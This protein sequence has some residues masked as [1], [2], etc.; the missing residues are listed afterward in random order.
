MQVLKVYDSSR[1]C[2]RVSV[3]LPRVEYFLQRVNNN[4]AKITKVNKI[5][6][7]QQEVKAVKARELVSEGE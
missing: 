3:V 7:P 4:G 6:C 1:P 5:T 2:A